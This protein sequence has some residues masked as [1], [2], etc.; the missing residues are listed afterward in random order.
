QAL[1]LQPDI[2]QAWYG[3]GVTLAYLGRTAEAVEWLCRAWRA[4]DNLPD[5]G[6]SLEAA[7]KALG[8]SPQD[9][10]KA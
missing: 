6:A 2:P 7:L 8:R 9:C 5:K 1:A 10:E 4:R 3:V